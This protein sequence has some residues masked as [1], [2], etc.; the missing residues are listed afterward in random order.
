MTSLLLIVDMQEGFRSQEAQSIIPQIVSLKNG[1]DG[2]VAFTKF[3]NQKGSL[4]ERQ[5][6]WSALQQESEQSILVEFNL[7]DKLLFHH[8]TY[9]VLTTELL[10]FIQK[11]DVNKVFLCGVYTDVC[12]TKAAMD[13]F[14]HHIDT[15]VVKDACASLH[16]DTQHDAAII[17]LQHILG[18]DHVVLAKDL[19][20]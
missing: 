9:A 10:D 7:E 4:F 12:I 14:D 16:G 17:S 18:K 1:F 15:F 11:N 13:C 5:L 3:V 20:K 2:V 6:Q 8:A 19:N